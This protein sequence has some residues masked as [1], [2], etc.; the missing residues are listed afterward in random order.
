MATIKIK[1]SAVPAKVPTTTD[2]ALGELAINTYDGRIYMKQ[3]S[4][5]P[6]I[7]GINTFNQGSTGAVTQTNT[8]KLQQIVSV[9]DFGAVGD[10]VTLNSTA[11]QHAITNDIA[12]IDIPSGAYS[13]N[14][15]LLIP[16]GTARV[17]FAGDHRIRSIIQPSA[18]DISTGPVNINALFINQDN[19][20]HFCLENIRLYASVGY[21]G[22]G[23][24]SQEGGGADSSAQCLFSGLFKNLWI[25]FPSTNS[26]F[27][28]GGAQNCV[29]DTATCEN[30]K[31]VFRLSGVGSGDNYF[32]NYSLYNCYD[33]F[34]QQT[35]DTNGS[36]VT[37]VYAVHAYNHQR[38]RLI[39][40]QNWTSGNFNDFIL[41]PDA[42]NLGDTGL[43][44]FKNSTGLNVSDFYAL[45]RSGVPA[46]SVGIQVD[47]V[48]AKFV[49][50]EINAD[51]GLYI[52]GTGA[53]DLEFVNVNFTNNATA[54][55]RFATAASGTIK[56]IGCTFSNSQVH[57]IL[58]STANSINWYSY[59]DTF[60]NAGLGGNAS[61]R[62][63]TLQSSGTIVFNNPVIG[64]DDAGAAAGYYIEANG[65][66][67]VTIINPTWVGTPASGL[68][69]GSQAV[70]VQA[71]TVT[72]VSVVNANGFAGTVATNTTT[73][74]I[75]LST[76]VTGV[77]K[78]NGTAISAATPGT[79]YLT[80]LSGDAT[81]SSNVITL[82]TVNSNVGQFAV[83][84]VNAK[85][86]VTAATTLTGD[87]TSSG[88]TTTLANTAV[89]AASYGSSTSIP[90]FTVD[91]KGR[92][93]AASG[94][95]VVAPAGTLSGST[96]AAGV[97]A[98]SLTS[99]GTIVTGGWNGTKVSEVYGGTN[100]NTYS[101]GDTLYAS[102]SNTLSKLVIG[103]T[104][105]VLTVAGGVPM[106]AAPATN[107]T[108]T[109]VA[110]TVPTFLSIA[111]S[112]ITS[113]GTLA[114]TL[115]G[116]ALPV[117]NGGTG[118]STAFTPGSLVFAGASGV[119]SQDNSQL[120]WDDTNFSLGIGTTTPFTGGTGGQAS[121]LLQIYKATGSPTISLVADAASPLY[122]GQCY[123]TTA[124]QGTL[125]R[126]LRL[127][128]TQASPTVAIAGDTT[129]AI[130]GFGYDGGSSRGIAQQSFIIDT[131]TGSNNISG[132]MTFSTRPD[133]GGAQAERLRIDKNGQ[134]IIQTAGTGISVKEG[135]NCKQ[136]K[137]TM[138]A[139]AV[140]VSTT[141]VTSSS[142]IFVS[143]NDTGS[144]ALTNIGSVYVN[145]II[146]GTSFDI[147]STNILDTS[148]IVW[149]IT[150]PS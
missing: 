103:S 84:T 13:L 22:V 112:P 141:A 108:V 40:V 51:T 9:Q 127:R 118:T 150:E 85:G 61:A 138:V 14:A 34:I 25:D 139:G 72:S 81:T 42:T 146:A 97:T 8:N 17:S 67:T 20:P 46:C 41:E 95:A 120:F 130:Q 5:S 6:S 15:P 3:D 80:V 36:F 125:V 7:V 75:T 135:T 74:A 94:N 111:G 24:Y 100:Q 39:D 117:A 21:T 140:T 133:G 30:M 86:L 128:G 69:T 96:L 54:A 60:L 32:S 45:T 87:V 132:Y 137:S 106:W 66:G 55:M 131:V 58:T 89:T 62:N 79:D 101:T 2:I 33:S 19:N 37:S 114:I 35:D 147:R 50:G 91:A 27:L 110:M 144:G 107:G 4:G 38:G 53:V 122:A 148:S 134:I 65:S 124:G 23:I 121:P 77:L 136:G 98:S 63:I 90:S 78:G 48:S 47:T 142:R 82:A 12:Q 11:F 29:F 113:S 145:N 16:N 70:V 149:L 116:T 83:Q 52:G 71:G 26:G 28:R 56:T 92:L 73:P 129:I 64:H 76:S 143:I 99:V 44:R 104:G 1:R 57:G 102:A 49:N 88:A 43:F 109:S 126:G 18:T 115:S 68:T 93:T 31:G 123:G 105:N 119:Y 10:G 59:G